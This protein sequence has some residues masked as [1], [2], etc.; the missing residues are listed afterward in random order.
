MATTT[1]IADDRYIVISS[2]C[3]AGAEMHTYR[4]YLE[5]RHLDDFDAWAKDFQNP[6]SDLRAETAYRNWDSDRRREELERDGI[7][8]EVLFPNTIPP[9]YP[10]G[11]LTARPPTPDE[12][13]LR[14]AGL[15]AHNRWL[16][17]F[18]NDVPGRRAG[19][20]QVL[21]HDVDAAVAEVEWAR[22]A[23][24]F[25][26]VLV[27]GIP[28]DSG[29]PAFVAP[30]YEPLWSVCEDLGMPVNHHTGTAAPDY[31]PYPA[32][33]AIWMMELGF[34]GHRI[35]WMLAFAGVFDR[36][37]NLHL[38]LTEGGTEWIPNTLS[39][40]DA[41]YGRFKVPGSAESHFGGAVADAMNL[42]PS[43]Y[44]ARQC[45]VGSS[46]MRPWECVLR[47][48]IGV[49]RIMW[50]QDYPHVEG[51]YPYTRE[52]LRFT[53]HD[54][55]PEDTAAMV[56][57]NAAGLYG[58]DLDALAPIA[59]QVGPSVSEVAVPL[60]AVPSDT[61]CKAFEEYAARPF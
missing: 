45:Y 23:G 56:G 20:A 6:F 14:W 26:G 22:E 38:V 9:F 48:E 42:S 43:E 27:P 11:N 21:L 24:L 40:M 46:F 1:A 7:V 3:H 13:E 32:S 61:V 47:D 33:M 35:F 59:A 5:Q 49:D 53:F 2:D 8:G 19:M 52:A 57:G 25:G 44:W 60:D 58:F 15:R 30:V 28:P 31:G 34:F 17:D 39:M 10:S 18:C 55:A 36:H 4:E 37:P 54:V 12:Y 16:V 51:T 29:I 50:G 41:V